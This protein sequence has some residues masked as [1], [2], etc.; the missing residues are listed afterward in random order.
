MAKLAMQQ[1]PGPAM[2]RLFLLSASAWAAAAG[3]LLAFDGEAALASRWGASS[4]ALVHALTLG[5]LGNAMFGSLLQFLPVAAGVRVRG[6]N[7]AARLLH[8]LLNLGTLGLVLGLRWPALLPLAWGGSL[9]GA[10]FALL[11]VLVAPG[12]YRAQGQHFLRLG[13]GSALLAAGVTAALGLL[14]VRVLA[15]TTALP[16]SEWVDVH[17]AWGLLGWVLGLLAAVSR[18]VAPMFQGVAAT[19]TRGQ[20]AW[21][22]GT[23]ALLIVALG[24]ALAGL[25]TQGLRI[26]AGLAGLAFA[27]A[28]LALQLRAPKLRKAPLTFFWTAGLLALAAGAGALLAGT[29]NALWVGVL[30]LGIGLPL[31]VTG[32]QLEI[33]AFLAWIGLQRRCG[34]G[35]HLP[36]VQLL[37]PE[38]DKYR[39]L[40]LQ[41]AAAPL[42]LAAVPVPAV[43]PAAGLA[44]LLAHA[45]AF[46]ALCGPGWRGRVF[47]RQR[48]A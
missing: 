13:I 26:G 41:L 24:L 38:R 23:Y 31:L 18:V 45:G 1:A 20:G 16:L 3:G 35:V 32:M 39:V 33:V 27:L 48:E 40:A 11:A 2:P 46:V 21:Q 10:A 25:G 43:A 6:G 30:V 34:R 47:I 22:A 17:A 7:G 44:L 12:L 8:A 9:L 29:G 15:G 37:A 19:S 4:L 36:G 42:L 5:Y 14:L 28:G